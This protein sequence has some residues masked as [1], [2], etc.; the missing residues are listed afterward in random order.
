MKTAR[1][2]RAH[3]KGVAL[4]APT[5]ELPDDFLL[6]LIAKWRLA[7]VKAQ[8]VWAIGDLVTRFGTLPDSVEQDAA[9]GEGVSPSFGP[10]PAP[11]PV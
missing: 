9:D 11:D 8:L 3:K 1:K 5:P 10:P 6:L 7:R 2:K 4:A